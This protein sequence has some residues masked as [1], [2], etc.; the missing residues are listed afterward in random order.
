MKTLPVKYIILGV[1]ITVLWLFAAFIPTY[2]SHLR[3][4]IETAEAQLQLTDFENTLNRLPEFIK[5]YNELQSTRK[6]LTAK[7]YTKDDV[8]RLFDRLYLEAGE[9]NL[10]ITEITPPIEELLSLNKQIGNPTKPLFLNI[11]VRMEGGYGDFARFVRAIE[12]SDFYRGT[13]LCQIIGARDEL[14][15]L[16]QVYGFKALLGNFESKS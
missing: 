3:V 4:E 6:N 15:H 11:S 10:T 16:R 12:R 5:G 2:R 14:F 1:A 8:L 13:N 9:R 7:L